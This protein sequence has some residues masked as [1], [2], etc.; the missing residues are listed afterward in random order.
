MVANNLG[1]ILNRGVRQ[2]AKEVTFC[3]SSGECQLYK[4]ENK[5]ATDTVASK[6]IKGSSP[7]YA[8]FTEVGKVTLRL[9]GNEALSNEPL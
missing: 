1:D 9:K 8:L 4:F 6:T 3:N 5:E 2:H 7:Y